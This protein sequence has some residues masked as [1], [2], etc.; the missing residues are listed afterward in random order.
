MRPTDAEIEARLRSAR[1]KEVQAQ[2]LA[3]VRAGN[4]MSFEEIAKALDVPLDV[5]VGGFKFSMTKAALNESLPPVGA[6]RQ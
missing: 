4:P 5:V 3:R 6:T 1:A 2:V